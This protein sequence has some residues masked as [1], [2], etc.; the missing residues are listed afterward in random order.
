MVSDPE[1]LQNLGELTSEV[2]PEAASAEEGGQ[3]GW[4]R[5]LWVMWIAQV[6]AIL[7]FS[8]VMPFIPFYV[9]ELGVAGDRAVALWAGVLAS[10]A[11]FA[12]AVV[13]PLWGRLADRVGRRPMVLRSMLGG[14]VVLASMGLATNVYQLLVLRV[15]QGV[16]TGT[17]AASVAMVSSMTPRKHLGYS[18]GLMQTAVFTGASVG[19]WIGG[20]TADFVGY[21]F[22]FYCT[23][24]MLLLAG[25]LVAF[26]TR[27]R[28]VR[29]AAQEPG[30]KGG[31]RGVLALPGMRVMLAVFLVVNLAGTVVGPIFPLYV[32]KLMADPARAASV[33]GLIMALTGVMAAVAAGVIGRL[34]DRVGHKRVLVLCTFA[35]GLLCLPQAAVTNVGQL[36]GLRALFGA[37]VGGTG[38]TINALVAHLVP[39]SGYGRAYGLTA[40]VSSLGAGIGP[41][42]GGVMASSLGLRW[43]FVL[44]GMVLMMLSGMAAWRVP[45]RAQLRQVAA[46]RALGGTAPVPEGSPA[47]CSCGR[48]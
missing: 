22:S 30:V 31:L 42:V 4:R 11:G 27:E 32:E 2:P 19:P 41:L 18:L 44:T 43:P 46:A 25:L 37:S 38:P 23:G 36:L 26:G 9:R 5:T 6:I 13:A 47:R 10:S 40:S 17:I 1:S 24:G 21:R 7:G 16:L 45:G 20:M 29:P 34:S 48:R 3:S 14:A 35:S 33:T 8:F 39:R 28:F 15:L 12:M